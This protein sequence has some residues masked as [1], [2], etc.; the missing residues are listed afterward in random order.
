MSR[1]SAIVK[2]DP[3]NKTDPSGESEA[4]AYLAEKAGFWLGHKQ[5]EHLLSKERSPERRYEIVMAYGGPQSKAGP[6]VN[7]RVQMNDKRYKTAGGKI[8]APW[9]KRK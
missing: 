1:G 2:G 7:K 4:G 3:I 6:L 9:F 8:F 5:A